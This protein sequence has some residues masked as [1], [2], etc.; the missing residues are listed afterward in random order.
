[1]QSRLNRKPLPSEIKPGSVIENVANTR[2]LAETALGPSTVE[3]PATNTGSGSGDED[4]DAQ[5]ADCQVI[6]N[7]KSTEFI[8]ATVAEES[9]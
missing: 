3:E 4:D 8:L 5:E 9:A 2:R 6:S 7:D 1:M